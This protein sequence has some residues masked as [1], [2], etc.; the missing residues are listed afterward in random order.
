LG[1]SAN[2]GVEIA[3]LL[4]PELE[5]VSEGSFW[6]KY[7]IDA[8]MGKRTVQIKNDTRIAFSHNIWHEIYEKSDMNDRQEWRK[9]PGVADEYIF[10]TETNIAWWGYRVPVNVLALIEKGMTMITIKPNNGLETSMGFLFPVD[11]LETYRIS[12]I[13]RTKFI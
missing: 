13:I 7:G 10:T 3:M 8:L 5:P 4:F 6:D 12:P 1:K 11:K 2:R 9:S